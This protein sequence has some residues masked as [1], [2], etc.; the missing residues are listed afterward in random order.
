[1]NIRLSHVIC[2]LLA[3]SLITQPLAGVAHAA[4]TAAAV[5]NTMHLAS[6]MLA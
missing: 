1:M 3:A 4:P 2:G 6:V 5:P